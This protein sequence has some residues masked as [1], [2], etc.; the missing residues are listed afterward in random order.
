MNFKSKVKAFYKGIV[1]NLSAGNSL[2]FILFY[3][4]FYKPEKGS[5]DDFTSRFS[6]FTGS[7]WVVQVGAN[8]GINNDPIHKFIRRDHWQGVLLE[9]QKYVFEKYLKPLYGKTKGIMVL[10]AALDVSDGFKPIYKISVSNS[11]WATGLT[12][13]NRKILE[14]AV[15]S[16]YIERQA[17]K[18]G[19]PLPENK[20]EY[21][22]EES[23][24]C[25]CTQ[26]LM[27][28]AG[29]E[30]TDWLQIDTEGFDFEII[31]MFDIGVTL[32]AVIVYENLHLSISDRKACLNHLHSNGYL[33]QD[34]GANTL[35]MRSPQGI[36]K[37]FFLNDQ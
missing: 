23:V 37:Q 26:T 19:C 24:E 15:K 3:R 34:Y 25:I 36:F 32:P 11:R 12:S 9:P 4:F 14:E 29:I 35:A 6:K 31:K 16:G 30:K 28:R 17:K 8:D 10:N 5:L 33:V 7:V 27:K 22:V 20:E 21:I 1:F 13:F 18:E 2:I